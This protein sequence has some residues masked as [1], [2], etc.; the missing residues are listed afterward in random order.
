M[1][2]CVRARWR[3]Y[4]TCALFSRSF[5]PISFLCRE[6]GR[7]RSFISAI[8]CV[9]PT[10]LLVYPLNRPH[11]S[12]CFA[13]FR[14]QAP[15]GLRQLRP[16]EPQQSTICETLLTYNGKVLRHRQVLALDLATLHTMQHTGQNGTRALPYTR[17]FCT[18]F[19]G[20]FPAYSPIST[21]S[22]V[23]LTPHHETTPPPS[24]TMDG[25]IAVHFGVL[26]GVG[27]LF[28]LPFRE[29]ALASNANVGGP[30]TAAAMA[31]AKGWKN[32]VSGPVEENS[33][34]F[35]RPE[36]VVAAVTSWI[37]CARGSFACFAVAEWCFQ[38]GTADA[39][40]FTNLTRWHGTCHG[41]SVGLCA[42]GCLS[43][44]L[45][46]QGR[47]GRHHTPP[48]EREVVHYRC[49]LPDTSRIFLF[50]VQMRD[51]FGLTKISEQKYVPRRRLNPHAF[52]YAM[53]SVAVVF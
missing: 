18:G 48:R 52:L 31:A 53:A 46:F 29:L 36:A 50:C 13:R 15:S 8:S 51:T 37:L 4:C 27:R 33:F 19:G 14:L 7:A 20:V 42:A 1:C 44:N 28:R 17:T 9:Q 32:L 26:V 47:G 5:F 16:I 6:S 40:A 10:I 11:S 23:R 25:Q 49:P 2:S 22:S 39:D 12:T 30:T 21:L 43:V 34:F 24:W 45:T 38:G 41:R 3:D 35:A